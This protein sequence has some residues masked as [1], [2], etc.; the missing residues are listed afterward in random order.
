MLNAQQVEG[1]LCENRHKD[2]LRKVIRKTVRT[3]RNF[4]RKKTLDVTVK[5][6]LAC[7]NGQ[8]AYFSTSDSVYVRPRWK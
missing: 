7:A 5:E 2:G 4:S 6:D 1:L 8:R 3:N